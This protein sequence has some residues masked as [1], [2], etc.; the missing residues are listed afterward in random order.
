MSGVYLLWLVLFHRHQR[1]GLNSTSG[2]TRDR[3]RIA[4]T[5]DKDDPLTELISQK[6]GFRAEMT[7]SIKISPPQEFTDIVAC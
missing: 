5:K 2:L 6:K 7:M 4:S 3:K 1:N